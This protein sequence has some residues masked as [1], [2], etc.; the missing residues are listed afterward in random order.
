MRKIYQLGGSIHQ[1]PF[2]KFLLEYVE[3]YTVDNR[4]QNP[5]H[6]LSS[7]YINN[8]I[9]DSNFINKLYTRGSKF[10]SF[11]SDL[12]ERIRLEA[13]NKKD[14]ILYKLTSKITSREIIMEIS[15]KV[16]LPY[17][18]PYKLNNINNKSIIIKP[19][20]A[21]GSRGISILRNYNYDLLNKKIDFARS[22]SLDDKYII[23]QVFEGDNTKY[24]AEA[25]CFNNQEPIFVWGKSIQRKGTLINDGSVQY[26]DSFDN[27][28]I[29]EQLKNFIKELVKRID[30]DFLPLNIDFFIDN[31]KIF[32]IESAPRPGGNSLGLM[33]NIKTKKNYF[34]NLMYYYLEE[35]EKF[36]SPSFEKLYDNERMYFI[37][38]LDKNNKSY[39]R[40]PNDVSLIDEFIYKGDNILNY[41]GYKIFALN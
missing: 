41:S 28:Q 32:V 7:N 22:N 17:L 5:G 24:Y 14:T 26:G 40:I 20:I 38:M 30:I 23:E 37:T 16:N 27:S 1:I 25:Y 29:S 11:G 2:I 39:L 21:S 6:E 4:P 31:G 19:N 35:N 12:A 3:V 34:T 9:I 36:I 13:K 33:L 8:T 15:A 18:M 10:S